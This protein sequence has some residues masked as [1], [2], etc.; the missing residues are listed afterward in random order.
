MAEP[1]PARTGDPD[2]DPDQP[3]EP[4]GDTTDWKSEAR[5]WEARA[6]KSH[7]EA[8]ANAAAAQRLR[9]LEDADKTEGQKAADRATAAEK[10][11]AEAEAKV[12]RLEIAAE[13]GLTPAQAKRLMGANR[14]ELEA[15][16][17]ELLSAFTPADD[18]KRD[19]TR[20]RPTEKL[21][22]G[23]I[24]DDADDEADPAKIAEGVLS[25][26]L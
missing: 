3:D 18:T 19:D 22:P 4:K 5:K 2:S 7:D 21:R 9:E 24:N 13:K 23:A 6:K 1:D 10:R 15:D 16:A 26:G 20:R 12:L 8:K 11:A 14:E 25:S 17:D